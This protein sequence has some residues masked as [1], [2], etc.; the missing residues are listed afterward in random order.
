MAD[1][2]HELT[3]ELLDGLER[4]LAEEYAKASR[5]MQRK[6][7]E[8][9]ERFDAEDAAQRKFLEA[10][11][12]TQADYSNWRFRHM[13][14]GK[15]WE[16]MRDTLAADMEHTNEIALRL[17]RGQMPDVYA[18]NANFGTY[19][20]EHDGRIDT[21]FTLYNHDAAERLLT[22][23]HQMMPGPS[24]RKAAKI[25]A[26]KSMQWNRQKIQS[27]VLQG[28]LQGESPYK[29]AERLRGVATMNYNA[30]VRYTRTMTTNAQNAGRYQSFRRAD[31]V[32]VNL[33][34]EWEA[35]LDGR[36]RHEHR[37]MHG[38]RR[39]VDEPFEIYDEVSRRTIKIYYPAQSDGPGASDIPQSMIW[40]CFVGDT[41]V[42]SDCEIVRSYKHKFKGNL[43]RVRTA[44]GVDFTCTPNHPIL[45]PDG[46][47][48]AAFLHKG[49]HLLITRVGDDGS[50]ARNGNVYHVHSSIKALHDSLES[51][52][53]SERIPMSN[54]DFHGDVP[55]SDVEVVSKERLL[56]N[57]G[58]TCGGQSSRKIRFKLPNAF[59]LCERHFMLGFRRIYISSLRFVRGCCKPLT[60]IW[61]RLR[62]ADIHGFGTVSNRDTCVSEYAINDLPTVTNIRSELLDG[63]AGNVFVDDV[64]S[65]DRKPGRLLCHVYNLQTESGYYFVGKSIPQNGEKYNGNYYAIAKNCRC[66]LLARVKGFEGDTVKSS[67]KMGGMSFEEWQVAKAHPDTQADRD[68]YAEYR[69]LLGSRAPSSYNAF[70]EMKYTDPEAW[71]ELKSR[72]QSKRV[73]RRAK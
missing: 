14:M 42:A 61:R 19:Q 8:Y 67:P 11:K 28:I 39:K 63:L 54:F 59:R 13:M 40:N 38:Q 9:M 62:H 58:N 64:V 30:S 15:R 2:G 45:T 27:A 35:T 16:A 46:W 71:E 70:R 68:Q 53:N 72:A 69:R 18:L 66:T 60:L 25:A 5:D 51:L 17:S 6:F 29:V 34:I 52:G 31:K 12:I 10:G 44:A 55:T 32:G 1:R 65:V 37:M 49:D 22:E 21:G 26:D 20:I 73:S 23:E 33:V 41:K 43:I 36:T 24:T 4:R 3:D 50:L 56:R 48:P 47:V 7:R 57:D